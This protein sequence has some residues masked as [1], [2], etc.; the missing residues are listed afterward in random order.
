[1]L[2]VLGSS[3][4]HFYNFNDPG[5][6]EFLAAYTGGGDECEE[7]LNLLAS[8]DAIDQ[9]AWKSKIIWS[10]NFIKGIAQTYVNRRVPPPPRPDNYIE[11]YS[12]DGVSTGSLQ[13]KV[14][15][16]KGREGNRSRGREG[17]KDLSAEN[18]PTTP[19]V[20]FSVDDLAVLWNDKRP[21][22]LSAVN[23]PLKRPAKDMTKIKDALKRNPEREWWERVVLRLHSSPHCRGNNDRGWK[24]SF[25]FM[26]GRA[27]VILDGKYDGWGRAAQSG[28]VDWYHEGAEHG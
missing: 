16:G 4:G 19:I 6:K 14:Q 9:E 10:S 12:P 5:D 25:D 11:Q 15:E 18:P 13:E 8:L 22:E 17:L 1:L 28:I 7:I 3:E 26:V 27:E 20:R 23:L 24:A 21:P 2:E